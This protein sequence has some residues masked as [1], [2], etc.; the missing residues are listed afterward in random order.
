MRYMIL[1]KASK[2][3][4]AVTWGSDDKSSSKRLEATSKADAIQMAR[5]K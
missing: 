3:S 4:E 2:N 1:V 5:L